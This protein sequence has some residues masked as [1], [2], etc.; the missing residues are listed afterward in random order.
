MKLL[1]ILS[2]H[3]ILQSLPKQILQN[4]HNI[5]L[6]SLEAASQRFEPI[7]VRVLGP[8]HHPAVAL[9]R[10]LGHVLVDVLEVLD[11]GLH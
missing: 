4:L 9:A 2:Q 5:L 3:R 1:P 6:T 7:L 8:H 11:H 10:D